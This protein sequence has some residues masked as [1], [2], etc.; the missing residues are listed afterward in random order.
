MSHGKL[1]KAEPTYNTGVNLP[2]QGHMGAELLTDTISL[3]A[4]FTLLFHN[5]KQLSIEIYDIP[6]F[7]YMTE[8]AEMLYEYENGVAYNDALLYPNNRV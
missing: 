8:K 4:N 6:S 2:A 3:F 5:H 1:G 7:H